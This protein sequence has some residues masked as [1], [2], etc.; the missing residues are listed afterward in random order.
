MFT[1]RR[2]G[3]YQYQNRVQ[4]IALKKAVRKNR[5]DIL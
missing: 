5:F 4:E 2:S 1:I 3:S